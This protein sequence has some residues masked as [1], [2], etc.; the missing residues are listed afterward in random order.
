MET[1]KRKSKPIMPYIL[2]SLG[3]ILAVTAIIFNFMAISDFTKGF[4]SGISIICLVM[5]LL[6]M[7]SH[8]MKSKK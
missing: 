4:V 7:A 2:L 5:G 6:S 8:S 3:I 1:N